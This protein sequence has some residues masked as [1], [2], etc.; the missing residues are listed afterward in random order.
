MT[1][2]HG[3]AIA[4][5]VVDAHGDPVETASVQ[6]LRLPKTGRGRPQMRSGT[7]TNDLGEFRIALLEPGRYLLFVIPRHDSFGEMNGSSGMTEP[8]ERLPAPTFYPGVSSL[9][10][11]QPITIER[12]GSAT[13]LEFSLIEGIAA[14]VTGTVVDASGEPVSRGASISVRPIVQGL[15]SNGFG[16]NG[17]GVRPDGTFRLRLLPGEYEFEAHAWQPGASGP[18]TPNS[19]QFGSARLTVSGDTSGLAIQLGF[20]ARIS[21]RVVFDGASPL[22]T[23]PPS[24]WQVQL[25]S[26]SQDSP[27]CRMGRAELTADF[28]FTVEG[29][30]GTCTVRFNGPF[31]R[32]SAKSVIYNGTEMLDQPVTFGAGQ[33]FRDVQVILTD[34]RNE[35]TFQV[36]DEH[37][38]R[39][40]EYVG[41]LFAADKSRWTEGS[42]YVRPIVPRPDSPSGLTFVNSG[43]NVGPGVVE[44]LPS[45]PDTIAGLPPADYFAIAV[46]DMEANMLRDPDALER[47]SRGATRVTLTEGAKIDVTLRR[48]KLSDLV[49]ER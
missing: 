31:G 19:E 38:Q 29:V 48:I 34:K 4:G 9:D 44:A 32:W 2:F 3:G 20:G 46:D 18:P 35:V 5:R 21:G 27:N 36:A 40:R 14:T 41:V 45:R 43:R 26:P 47:L 33:R 39:T 30:F 10:Q 28:T 6:A 8:A 15:P 37:G 17:T 7:S 12:G 16:S 24:P 13:G 42:R 23:V 22:P 49:A 25:V 11:A 1:L